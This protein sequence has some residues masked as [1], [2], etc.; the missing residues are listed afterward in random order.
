MAFHV[1]K[2][3][4]IHI[5]INSKLLAYFVS[6]SLIMIQDVYIKVILP[7]VNHGL[8]SQNYTRVGLLKNESEM[9][10]KTN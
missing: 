8:D 7:D 4:I 1:P 6:E 10:Q 9:N 2:Y 3:K 5:T